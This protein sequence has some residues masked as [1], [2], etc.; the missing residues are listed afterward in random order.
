[1]DQV[2]LNQKFTVNLICKDQDGD[3][4]DLTGRTAHFY[5]K[6]PSGNETIDTSPTTDD[7]AGQVTHEFAANALDEEGVWHCRPS[8]IRTRCRQRATAS[9]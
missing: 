1:M 2:F 7:D 8:S 9:R 5:Y 4:I 6:D 3:V